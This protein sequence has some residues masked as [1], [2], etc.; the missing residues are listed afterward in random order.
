MRVLGPILF[1]DS[2]QRPNKPPNLTFNL[3]QYGLLLSS[4]QKSAK[5]FTSW[6]SITNVAGLELYEHFFLPLA[7]ESVFEVFLFSPDS[8]WIF[9]YLICCPATVNVGNPKH[10]LNIYKTHNTQETFQRYHHAHQTPIKA[11]LGDSMRMQK[12]MWF[13]T[14]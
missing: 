13:C 1:N 5:Y 14:R 11:C 4:E 8:P 9:I 3:I 6:N 2:D 12:T 10:I 7:L